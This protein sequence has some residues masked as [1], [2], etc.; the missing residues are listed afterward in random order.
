MTDSVAVRRGVFFTS[1]HHARVW[2]LLG[3]LLVLLVT[4]ASVMRVPAPAEAVLSHDKLVHLGVYAILMGWFAQIYQRG[5]AR[6]LL[7]LLLVAMG[8]GI[9][10][11]QGSTLTRQFD[12]YD[13]IA[14]T[15][16][17]LLAWALVHTPLGNVLHAVERRIDGRSAQ[18]VEQPDSSP[19]VKQ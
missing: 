3:V 4:I 9:E 12:R 19:A 10:Y 11:W 14:N 6:V 5:T 7:A 15:V 13:M 17:V 8:I 16:G 2:L 18:G 1:L